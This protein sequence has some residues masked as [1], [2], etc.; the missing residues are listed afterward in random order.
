MYEQGKWQGMKTFHCGTCLVSE[1][2]SCQ[3]AVS[4]V[5]GLGWRTR[6]DAAVAAVSAGA[7]AAESAVAARSSRLR[8]L[9]VPLRVQRVHAC[10]LPQTKF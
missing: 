2:D 4:V 5:D 1:S 9:G 6:C 8:G 10:H 3:R 7:D